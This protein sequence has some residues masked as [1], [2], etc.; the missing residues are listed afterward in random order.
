[1]AENG[2]PEPSKVNRD[3]N[4][5]E[6]RAARIEKRDG[7]ALASPPEKKPGRSFVLI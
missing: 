3:V 6:R 1:M 5:L 7:E 4:G 2:N